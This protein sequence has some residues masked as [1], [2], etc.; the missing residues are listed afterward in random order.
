MGVVDFQIVRETGFKVFNR[1]EVASFQK[2]TGD[3]TKPQRYLIA[4]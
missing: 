3:D 4:P 1:T 2:P